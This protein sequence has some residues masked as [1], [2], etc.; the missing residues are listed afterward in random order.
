MISKAKDVYLR[1]YEFPFTLSYMLL[2]LL[3]VLAVRSLQGTQQLDLHLLNPL[4]KS[5]R[6][7]IR[8]LSRVAVIITAAI[9]VINT[10]TFLGF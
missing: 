4:G 2:F 1:R 7:F 10:A 8:K 3:S 6:L 5:N 9:A